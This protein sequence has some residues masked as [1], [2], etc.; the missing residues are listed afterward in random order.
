MKQKTKKCVA[1]KVKVSAKGKIVR[2]HQGQNHFNA[3]E[4]GKT[5]RAKRRSQGMF[6][7]DQKNVLRA[8]PY[9]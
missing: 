7:T 5:R 4:S 9:L 2:R 6:D 8:V 3:K 1:K